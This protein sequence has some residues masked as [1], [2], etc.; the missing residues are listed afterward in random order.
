MCERDCERAAL[1]D[2]I[3]DPK[4]RPARGGWGRAE[5]TNTA[6][7]LIMSATPDLTQRIRTAVSSPRARARALVQ[8]CTLMGSRE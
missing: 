4:R 3:L 5:C 8:A 7:R 6:V 1:I 2:S